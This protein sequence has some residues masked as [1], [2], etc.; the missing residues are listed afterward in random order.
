[1]TRF[2]KYFF[3]FFSVGFLFLRVT[4]AFIFHEVAEEMYI[5]KVRLSMLW[6]IECC[7]FFSLFL[8][9]YRSCSK[10]FEIWI[11][12]KVRGK[13]HLFTQILTDV[14][15]AYGYLG[16]RSIPFQRKNREILIFACFPS[17]LLILMKAFSQK[18]IPVL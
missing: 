4:L 12:L 14:C 6:K 13:F 7:G 18:W 10:C 1:M 8:L 5:E 2:N 9:L 15:Y 16:K 11:T 17:D 3:F